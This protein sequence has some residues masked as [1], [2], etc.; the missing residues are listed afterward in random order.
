MHKIYRTQCQKYVHNTQSSHY[1]NKW[2][3]CPSVT[4]Q[5][6]SGSQSAFTLLCESL[7]RL[8]M[9]IVATFWSTTYCTSLQRHKTHN[10][11]K[12]FIIQN[13]WKVLE[14]ESNVF[15]KRLNGEMHVNNG[16]CLCSEHFSIS[17]ANAKF[18]VRIPVSSSSAVSPV[19]TN[20]VLSQW[21]ALHH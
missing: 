21:P 3:N 14:R 6:S 18:C 10:T 4:L 16:W 2:S 9:V 17:A 15:I 7:T 13:P 8:L 19:L 20:D 12:M 5:C 11:M 1:V